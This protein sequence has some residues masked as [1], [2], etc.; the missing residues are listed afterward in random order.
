MYLDKGRENLPEVMMK[1]QVG[2]RRGSLV[3]CADYVRAVGEIKEKKACE[4]K[5]S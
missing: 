4:S 5:A 3:H 1:L 2:G